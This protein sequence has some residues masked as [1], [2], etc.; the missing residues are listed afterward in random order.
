MIV[1][2]PGRSPPDWERLGTPG[3]PPPGLGVRRECAI[4]GRRPPPLSPGLAGTVP[5]GLGAARDA[6]STTTWPGCKAR[7]R[8]S[9]MAP[10]ALVDRPR[11]DGDHITPRS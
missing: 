4:L 5:T 8:H 7:M 2:F 6:R 10:T 11:W 9:R 3:P 1:A